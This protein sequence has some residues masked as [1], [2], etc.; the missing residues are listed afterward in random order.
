VSKDLASVEGGRVVFGEAVARIAGS[1]NPLGAVGRVVAESFALTT[2]IRRI[3]LEG[4]Q[5]DDR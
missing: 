1:L 4:R 3:N 5:N 2:E